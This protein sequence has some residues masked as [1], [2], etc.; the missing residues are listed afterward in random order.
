MEKRLFTSSGPHLLVAVPVA[1][2]AAQ[3]RKAAARFVAV[4]A[5]GPADRPSKGR[6]SYCTALG[7]IKLR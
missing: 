2:G 5:A 4:V 3:E 6:S 7:V 1:P